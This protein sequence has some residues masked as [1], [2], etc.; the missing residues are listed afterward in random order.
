MAPW[1]TSTERSR[2]TRQRKRRGELPASLTA[3]A[4]ERRFLVARG[5]LDPLQMEAKGPALNAAMQQFFSDQ[6]AEIITRR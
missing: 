6:I 5:Y 1:H 2:T 3:D 4:V